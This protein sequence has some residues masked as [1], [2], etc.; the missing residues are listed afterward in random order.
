ME[1]PIALILAAG[2]GTRL[3][4]NL[5]KVLHEVAGRPMLAYVMEALLLAGVGRV[6][7]VV[8]HQA[9]AVRSLVSG[10][11]VE[12]AE[13]DPQMGT[14]HAVMAAKSFFD[15]HGG[16]V[17]ILCGD[18]PLI[19]AQSIAGLVRAHHATQSRLTVVTA[20]LAD[21]TGYGRVIRNPK[22][23]VERI[24]EEKDAQDAERLCNEINTGVYLVTA[25]LLASLLPRIDANNAQGEYY[26]TDLV[27]EAVKDGA[28]VHGHL[29]DNSDEFEGINTR[30]QLARAAS[31]IWQRNRDELM[32]GGVTLLDPATV[33]PD[34]D[35]V[36]GPDTIIYPGVTISGLTRIGSECVIESGVLIRD[37]HIGDRVEVRLGTRMEKARIGDGSTIGPMAHLRPDSHV[38]RNAR[39]GNFVETK[40]TFLGDGSKAAHLTYLGDCRVGTEVNIGCGTITCNYDGKHKYTTVIND[41]CFIGSDVQLVAPV[42]IGEGSVIGAGSTITRDVPPRSLAVSRVKQKVYPLRRGQGPLSSEAEGKS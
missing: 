27:A 5:C 31:M 15:G 41:H 40:K 23:S 7:V 39:V 19:R 37:C 26:L 18:T 36:V 14:A 12:F 32:R 2:K 42:E 35:V 9:E 34:S 33:Y 17:L 3:K 8:G 11:D 13:Q 24:V 21:P 16:D 28:T 10:Y 22:G 25:E 6:C 20:S 4:S 30:A 1:Q 29:A 38:G